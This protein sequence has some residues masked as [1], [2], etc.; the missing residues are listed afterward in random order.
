MDNEKIENKRKHCWINQWHQFGDYN[1]TSLTDYTSHQQLL[2]QEQHLNSHKINQ[3]NIS[4]T[5]PN[6]PTW[7]R[8]NRLM[9]RQTT[10]NSKSFDDEIDKNELL[11]FNHNN[12]NETLNMLSFQSNN[13]QIQPKKSMF[14]DLQIDYAPTVDLT[15]K[16]ESNIIKN[17]EIGFNIANPLLQ[18]DI[19]ERMKP[20]NPNLLRP[21]NA[22]EAGLLKGETPP[23]RRV[24]F[25]LIN[26]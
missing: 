7:A 18:N 15:Y 5:I 8:R 20:K 13:N 4:S 1:T 9:T 19:L 23:H 12:D 16:N 21:P 14:S 24:K 2:Y 11:N 17:K 3:H 25:N 10:I 6:L 26:V 22:L